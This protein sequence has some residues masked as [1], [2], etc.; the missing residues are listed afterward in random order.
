MAIYSLPPNETR[1]DGS[2]YVA[3][4]AIVIGCVTLERRS[5]VWF[6]AVIRGTTSG[7]K[8][9]RTAMFRRAPC[10]TPTSVFRCASASA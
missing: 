5:S 9:V 4:G 8:S 3:P 2:A 7:S 1:I 10:C 6:N